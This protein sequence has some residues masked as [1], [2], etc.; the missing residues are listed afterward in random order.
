MLSCVAGDIFSLSITLNTTAS[1]LNFT[2]RFATPPETTTLTPTTTHSNGTT[3]EPDNSTLAS[4]ET[5][6][7]SENSTM[8]SNET[9]SY[10]ENSTL[11]TTMG[12]ENTTAANATK[13]TESPS[14]SSET[15]T[16]SPPTHI[17]I[18]SYPI[19]APVEEPGVIVLTPS[20]QTTTKK[21][22]STTEATT[23]ATEATT[24][25]PEITTAGLEFS[26]ISF[27]VALHPNTKLDIRNAI[28]IKIG[29]EKSEID[30]VN[31]LEPCP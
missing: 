25:E 11:E 14:P 19:E 18:A 16:E 17:L 20:P 3:A 29:Y 1:I 26:E 8:A 28:Y 6:S 9:I 7:N 12:S 21:P 31:L 15:T 13:S 24:E 22:E 10:S 30:Y 2:L 23:E 4:N 5:I 27:E